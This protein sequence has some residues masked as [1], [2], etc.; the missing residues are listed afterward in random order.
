VIRSA[1]SLLVR[2]R[3]AGAAFGLLILALVGLQSARLSHAKVDLQA[4]RAALHDPATGKTWRSEAAAAGNSLASCGGKLRAAE[5]ALHS[6]NAA[7]ENLHSEADRTRNR[8][9]RAVQSARVAGESERRAASRT[10]AKSAGGDA[11][12]SADEL[13]LDS[14]QSGESK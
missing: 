10:M 12:R 6:Q 8:L 5:T 3:V 4:A 9:L 14:L 1:L 13:I 11:C 2:P 7:I